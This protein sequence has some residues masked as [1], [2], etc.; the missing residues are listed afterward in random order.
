MS[1]EKILQSFRDVLKNPTNASSFVDMM[2]GIKEEQDFDEE[3]ATIET[4]IETPIPFEDSFFETPM[5][6]KLGEIPKQNKFLTSGSNIIKQSGLLPTL[7]E[8]ENLLNDPNVILDPSEEKRPS[9]TPGY[10]EKRPSL[11]DPLDIQTIKRSMSTLVCVSPQFQL[12]FKIK[13]I[14]EK[15]NLMISVYRKE[16][17]EKI[18]I[19]NTEFSSDFT[20]TTK[21]TISYQ[22]ENLKKY[23]FELKNEKGDVI[24]KSNCFIQ[25]LCTKELRKELFLKNKKNEPIGSLEI[26]ANKKNPYIS[27]EDKHKNTQKEIYLDIKIEMEGLKKMENY[28][29]LSLDSSD[30]NF[31]KIYESEIVKKTKNP[32][33][34]KFSIPL[35][36]K[37]KN[38]QKLMKID[39]YSGKSFTGRIIGKYNRLLEIERV[40][41]YDKESRECGS[42]KLNLN[43]RTETVL[44]LNYQFSF[45][46]FIK[47]GLKFN[48]IFGIDFSNYNQKPL[49]YYNLHQKKSKNDFNEYEKVMNSFI[50]ILKVYDSNFKVLAFG[51]DDNEKYVDLSNSYDSN[52]P[53]NVYQQ[54]LKK[55]KFGSMRNKNLENPNSPEYNGTNEFYHII[56]DL[57]KEKTS[58]LDTYTIL[59][60]LIPNDFINVRQTIEKFIEASNNSPISILI[61]G[62]GDSSFKTLRSI[63]PDPKINF[64]RQIQFILQDNI[65]YINNLRLGNV[66]A[67]REVFRFSTLNSF[68]GNEMDL[69]TNLLSFIPKHIVK[70]MTCKGISPDDISHYDEFGPTTSGGF[71]MMTQ[72]KNIGSNI[73]TQSKS[74]SGIKNEKEAKQLE[75]R[76][77]KLK[78]EINQHQ[79]KLDKAHSRKLMTKRVPYSVRRKLIQKP[80]KTKKKKLTSRE[81]EMRHL[82]SRKM[83]KRSKRKGKRNDDY[84]KKI[85]KYVKAPKAPKSQKMPRIPKLKEGKQF[86]LPKMPK[87][88]KFK[89]PKRRNPKFKAPS[90]Y[91]RVNHED[92]DDYYGHDEEHDDRDHHDDDYHRSS[93]SRRSKY[94]RRRD[95]L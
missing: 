76:I 37:L 10:F 29:K 77:M 38:D 87:M 33:F 57:M 22:F 80:K 90:Y 39:F 60:L 61:V 41:M 15:E 14:K 19:G 13:D 66:K 40:T 72:M 55:V 1:E 95:E 86:K 82:I 25:E 30:M 69:S 70:F 36:K 75:A 3:E 51:N 62:I 5:T 49:Q 85:P 9:L 54:F 71:T 28:F 24:G 74:R 32:K 47:S 83:R 81:R 43:E 68:E 4:K 11:F 48:V 88:P 45:L 12:S 59:I 42:I 31:I 92:H 91:G 64:E 27:N 2:A 16:L 73:V 94:K 17:N 50:E 89:M 63:N 52:D 6:I 65:P 8:T 34:K 20:F 46:D 84:I 78:N 67:C 18:F 44:E 26:L 7:E 56:D 58:N 79:K 53:I 21:I 93:Y 35:T 23:N